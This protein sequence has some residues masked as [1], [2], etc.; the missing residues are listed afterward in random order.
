MSTKSNV[1]MHG[2]KWKP[3]PDSHSKLHGDKIKFSLKNDPCTQDSLLRRG[4][5]QRLGDYPGYKVDLI[6]STKTRWRNPSCEQTIDHSSL[7]PTCMYE[8]V[9]IL[10]QRTQPIRG[11][12]TSHSSWELSIINIKLTLRTY[13]R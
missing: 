7:V 3:Y 6:H 13:K 10:W 8:F 11:D 9:K 1:L 4:P 12:K 5:K 2:D